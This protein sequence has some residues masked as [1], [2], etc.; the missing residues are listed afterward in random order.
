MIKKIALKILKKYK[1]LIDL[2]MLFP[3]GFNMTLLIE[4]GSNIWII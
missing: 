3:L 2:K 1:I 4:K